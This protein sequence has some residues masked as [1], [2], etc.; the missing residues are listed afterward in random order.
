MTDQ[1]HKYQEEYE[2]STDCFWDTKPAKY[3]KVLSGLLNVAGLKVL[4]IG[5]GE[6]KNSVF[7]ADLGA[8]VTAVEISSIALNR[9]S[10]QPNYTGCH[11]L[12]TSINTDIS[13]I[14]FNEEEF[15]VIIAYG[16][17]H[18]FSHKADIYALLKRIKTWV[19][20]GGYFVCATFTNLI[21]PP[22]F[23][24]Y[25]EKEAFLDP[26]ELQSIFRDWDIIKTEDDIIV[27]THP[28]SNIEHSHSIVRLICKK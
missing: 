11:G 7:L 4:D 26:G 1:K 6:G 9:F 27:E 8:K 21:P 19:K 20:T 13:S 3:V 17:L 16:I 15:D 12:I 28:T 5:A 24:D 22:P 18:C 14:E 25:L 23:Q 2:K 10:F